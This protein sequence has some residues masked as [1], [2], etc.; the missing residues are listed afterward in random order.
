MNSKNN[1]WPAPSLQD[2]PILM[3][4]KRPVHIQ[5]FREITSDDDVMLLFIFPHG[6]KLNTEAYIKCLEKIALTY[7]ECVAGGRIYFRQQDS[8]PC[9]TNRRTRCWLWEKSYDRITSNDWPSNFQIAIPL[10]IMCR[11]QLREKPSKLR[12]TTKMNWRDCQQG[13]L[14]IRK[15]SGDRG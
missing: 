9:H 2:V 13:F 6:L 10:F 4:T 5:A 14:E 7:I 1:C 8:A 3:K 12:E 11:T 15:S